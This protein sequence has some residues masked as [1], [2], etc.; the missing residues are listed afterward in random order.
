MSG[1]ILNVA[2]VKSLILLITST[3]KIFTNDIYTSRYSY[4]SKNQD[5]HLSKFPNGFLV[6]NFS[7]VFFYI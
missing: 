1:L 5:R 4:N 3:N 7:K 2:L 6:E